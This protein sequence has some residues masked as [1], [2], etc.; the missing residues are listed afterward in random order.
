MVSRD[1]HGLRVSPVAGEVVEPPR[2]PWAGEAVRA[3]GAHGIIRAMSATAPETVDLYIAAWPE[4]RRARLETIRAIVR[5]LAPDA[6]ELV[7]YG[8]PSYK[9]GRRALV[10][11]GAFARHDSIFPASQ[12]VCDGL[13]ELVA[14]HVKGRGTFQFPVRA[15]LPLDVVR[16]IVAARINEVRA[17]G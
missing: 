12:V 14:P 5:E 1:P 4:D 10:S 13:G 17:A 15:P 9:L 7:S 8:M 16:A 2:S 11:F 3:I 6:Q